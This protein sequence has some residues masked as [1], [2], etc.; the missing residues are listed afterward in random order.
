MKL[1]HLF[2]ALSLACS[3]LVAGGP[4]RFESARPGDSNTLPRFVSAG[5]D[6]GVAGASELTVLVL[7]GRAQEPFPANPE[8]ESRPP[9]LVRPFSPPATAP[10]HA[11]V[12]TSALPEPPLASLVE[13]SL[14]R[15]APRL[16]DFRPALPR[17]PGSA[18]PAEMETDSALYLQRRLGQWGEDEAVR[19]LGQPLRRRDALDSEKKPD[20][21]IVAFSDPSERYREFE[22]DFDRESGRLRAVFVY[23]WNMR[24]DDC[25]RLWGANVTTADA[26]NGRRFHSYENRRLDV[27]V[28]RTGN[29]ISLGLY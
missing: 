20:G 3:P 26:A 21:S 14:R 12:A 6:A 11:P 10:A 29:V 23:P 5:P 7:P 1:T 24:W 25:R 13:V 17:R 16:G 4:P 22:L 15:T 19:L 28:D 27:L 9:R 18:L 2:A 8:P